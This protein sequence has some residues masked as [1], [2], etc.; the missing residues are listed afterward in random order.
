MTTIPT[1]DAEAAL[2][3]RRVAAFLAIALVLHAAI[4]GL[5]DLQARR[6]ADQNPI[7]RIRTAEPGG[8]DWVVLGASHAMPLDFQGFGARIAETT[9]QRVLNLA[10]PG[11]GPLYHRF[12]AER[13]FATHRAEAVLVVVDSFAFHSGKWNED[14]FGDADLLARTPLERITLALMLRYLRHGVDPRA[15]LAYASGFAR[16]NN[17]DRFAPDRWAGED[18]FDRSPRPSALADRER[19]DYL[20]PDP[21]DASVRARY[22]D[23][24]VA[25][26][27]VAR[28]AGARVVVIKP[29]L[30]ARF[31]ALLPEE[32]AFDAALAELLT[33]A[34]VPFH[35]FTPVLPDPAYYFDP[36]HLNR[37]GAERFLAEHLAPILTGAAPP[38]R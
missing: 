22:L 33:T 5:A 12:L 29:P 16:I 37:R 26:V 30:P 20:Y 2:R 3:P 34:E 31:A 18:R 19:I 38:P 10:V 24:L 15:A 7:H 8:Q 36:D 27:E 21:P 1:P 11:T 17:H 13:F 14:R 35:D 6:V 25:L 4:F 28:A 23:H 9:G 32:A